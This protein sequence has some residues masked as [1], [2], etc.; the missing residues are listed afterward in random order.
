M[1]DRICGMIQIRFQ[2][3]HKGKNMKRIAILTFHRV[4][5]YGAV[6]QAYALQQTMTNLGVY[7]EILD[8]LRPQ[9]AGYM[10]TSSNTQL[11]PY[12]KSTVDNRKL[13]S[14]RV[15]ARKWVADVLEHLILAKRR[16][17]FRKF[18]QTHLKFSPTTYSCTEDLY[19]SKLDYD[20]YVTGSDQ[21]WNPTYRW[22]P[23]PFFLTFTT[24]GI[25]RIA[26][27][28]SFGVSA[29]DTAV[30]PLYARWL[31]DMTH[32]SVREIH[33][34]E[35]VKQLTGRNAEIVLDPTLL[36]TGDDCKAL[37]KEPRCKKPYIFCYSVG[38][39]PGLM[40]LCYHAQKLTGYPIYKIRKAREAAK[41][42]CNWR[43]KAVTDAG[44]Q[45]FLGY[46]MNAAIIVTNSFHGT[47]LSINLQKPFFTVPSPMTS[48][49]SRNSRLSSIL[50]ILSATDRL[51][52]LDQ[53][54]PS[55]TDFEMSY[56]KI[57]KK[58]AVEREKSLSYLKHAICERKT[59]HGSRKGILSS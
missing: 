6:L 48:T 20:A 5:N 34:A 18:D 27:A 8:L 38:D 51:Y 39:V 3:P 54:L 1:S 46:L 56:D 40:A 2:W 35:I 30:Q 23:E 29:I 57:F 10:E 12:R 44:P 22:S 21:V 11:A 43:I 25:P 42:V 7:C 50:Q 31:R 47:V 26:Y 17:Q 14:M 19:A 16:L 53:E 28:P 55:I 15:N 58:L 45:E 33:G 24:P 9:H 41:D 4:Q 13:R 59:G 52:Q 49:Q 32:L 37:A 36:L